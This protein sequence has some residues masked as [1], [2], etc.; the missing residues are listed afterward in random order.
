MSPP[1]E[2]ARQPEDRGGQV[3]ARDLID[4]YC[5]WPE[6]RPHAMLLAGR[7]GLSP[8]ERETVRWLMLLADRVSERD[9][10]PPER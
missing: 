4:F 1:G 10:R 8:A 7:S 3:P 6:F 5:R 9:I 2:N